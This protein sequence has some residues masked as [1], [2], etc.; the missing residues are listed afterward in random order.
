MIDTPTIIKNKCE[1][2]N[3][4]ILIHNKIIVCHSCSKIVHAK[5]SR[6]I[7]AYNEMTDSWQCSLCIANTPTKYNPFATISYDKHDPVQLDGF[8]DIAEIKKI[9]EDCK[10]YNP[11][12]FLD[13]MCF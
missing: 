3:K 2:C 6:N 12:N 8:E 1:G 5:C 7:F 4:F 13:L 10:T 11:K 9:L